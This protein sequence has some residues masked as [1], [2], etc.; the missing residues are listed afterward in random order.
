MGPK[1]LMAQD[2]MGLTAPLSHGARRP[3]GFHSSRGHSL[4]DFTVLRGTLP[5]HLPRFAVLLRRGAFH[6]TYTIPGRGERPGTLGPIPP[7]GRYQSWSKWM[8][9]NCKFEHSILNAS[10]LPELQKY[11]R[12]RLTVRWLMWLTWPWLQFPNSILNCTCRGRHYLH[13]VPPMASSE[14]RLPSR[15]ALPR[16]CNKRRI[17]NRFMLPGTNQAKLHKI[18]VDLQIVVI[19]MYIY[20]L[21]PLFVYYYYLQS[22]YCFHCTYNHNP[23]ACSRKGCR[24]CIVNSA[25]MGTCGP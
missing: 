25:G 8:A 16:I 17:A 14:L 6:A 5:Q 3:H 10:P 1:G 19:Y 4:Y 2:P 23:D 9:R 13:T 12:I 22:A 24:I 21:L 11:I 15:L 18:T 20:M 7:L